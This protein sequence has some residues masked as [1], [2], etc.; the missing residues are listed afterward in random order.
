MAIPSYYFNFSP[1]HARQL[2]LQAYNFASLPPAVQCS[3]PKLH[4]LNFV[5]ANFHYFD[6]FT[7]SLPIFFYLGSSPKFCQL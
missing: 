3:L 7:E 2:Q 4:L 6:L 1:L 5:R